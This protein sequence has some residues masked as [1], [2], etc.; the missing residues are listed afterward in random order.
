MH[1]SRIRFARFSSAWFLIAQLAVFL[2]LS[3]CGGGAA[4]VAKRLSSAAEIRVTQRIFGGVQITERRAHV[5]NKAQIARLA[6]LLGKHRLRAPMGCA[7]EFMID[8]LNAEGRTQLSITVA[9]PQ[10][11]DARRVE[12]L[13]AATPQLKQFLAEL[14]SGQDGE[15]H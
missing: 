13:Y 8:A 5:T 4:D 14:C 6:R 12:R 15:S 3:G 1:T 9:G 2:L 10:W 7:G 11:W